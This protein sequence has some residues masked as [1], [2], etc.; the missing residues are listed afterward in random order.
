[1]PSPFAR[2]N[3]VAKADVGEING[4]AIANIAAVS[5][6]SL[7]EP[8]DDRYSFNAQTVN[9]STSGAGWSP[10]G[11]MSGWA[12][13]TACT[14]ASNNRWVQNQ[15]QQVAGLSTTRVATGW[16]I[17]SNA[18]GSSNTGPNGA[19][20]G[21]LDGGTEGAHSTVSSTRYAYAE[22]SGSLDTNNHYIMRTP[23][24][25]FKNVMSSGSNNL[26]LEFY[27]HMYGSRPGTLKIYI[28]DAASSASDEATLLC[29][30]VGSYNSTT[31][32]TTMTATA[33]SH[34]T[35]SPASATWSSTGSNWVQFAIGLNNYRN[36][37]NT[38][39][40]YLVY[41]ADDYFTGDIAID[42]IG[43]IERS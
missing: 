19:H 17:D 21:G 31:R 15:T 32:V 25:V 30:I 27:M 38:N 20:A 34:A 18:T 5:A 42:D 11:E 39:Y 6:V 2:F 28:D 40:L 24:Y 14:S 29:G 9:T 22:T 12:S 35:V 23:G 16:R 8:L 3:R 4:T 43:V 41:E 37:Q 33:T 26:N 7:Q 10:S 1:M 36:S 13:G